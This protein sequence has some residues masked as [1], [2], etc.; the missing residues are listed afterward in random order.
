MIHDY[1]GSPESE[2][3]ALSDVIREIERI[4]A[5]ATGSLFVVGAQARDLI[6]KSLGFVG[7]LRSTSD[8]DI[9]IGLKDWSG[10]E[11]IRN[12][13]PATGHTG[14]RFTIAGWPVDI[15]PF[16]EVER[17]VGKVF[18][19][20]RDQEFDVFGM[21]EAYGS[22]DELI[23][24][25]GRPAR[26]P[27]PAGYAALKIKSWVDRSPRPDT[28]DAR[29]FTVALHWYQ[30]SPVL[31][32]RLWYEQSELVL[33]SGSDQDLAAAAMLG[34]DIRTVLGGSRSIE[35]AQLWDEASR[36]K[37][38]REMRDPQFAQS[39]LAPRNRDV[40]DAVWWR[41]R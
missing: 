31:V 1:S 19:P 41:L 23:L 8:I 37:M 4:T 11:D 21:Q 22:S 33:D 34:I 15:L 30:E 25:Y 18:P 3:V 39:A 27:S 40:L 9:A 36:E 35:L 26:M 24:P 29:D 28:R 5:V 16:G 2:L 6:H 17:G 10:F 14:M 12:A 32:E 7:A 13:V 38:A 20:G